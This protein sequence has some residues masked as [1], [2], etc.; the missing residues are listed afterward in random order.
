MC[1]LFTGFSSPAQHTKALWSNNKVTV[2]QGM[3]GRGNT[4]L[5]SCS[6]NVMPSKFT[7]EIA[8]PFSFSFSKIRIKVLSWKC[9]CMERCVAEIKHFHG[10][11][12]G[13]APAKSAASVSNWHLRFACR[14]VHV[15]KYSNYTADFVR[16]LYSMQVRAKLSFAWDAEHLKCWKAL[17][18]L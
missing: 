14:L 1:V 10:M 17:K 7:L 8:M 18:R 13:K 4:A 6:D 11:G 16:A 2:L 15:L 3:G 9:V 5:V 12:N